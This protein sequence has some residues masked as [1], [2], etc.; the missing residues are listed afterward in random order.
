MLDFPVLHLFLEFAQTHVIELMMPS[1]HLILC[2]NIINL[3][4]VLTIR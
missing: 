1:N 4:L 3:I 2:K